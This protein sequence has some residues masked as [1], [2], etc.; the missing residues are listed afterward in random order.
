MKEVCCCNKGAKTSQ[1]GAG[2]ACLRKKGSDGKNGAQANAKEELAKAQA[3]KK[4]WKHI[5]LKVKHRKRLESG[6]MGN[7]CS[8]MNIVSGEVC[9]LLV[10]P[11]LIDDQD[12]AGLELLLHKKVRL[13]PS[14]VSIYI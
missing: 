5:L 14:D 12:M 4:L 11:K 1:G 8:A 3:E 13:A 9:A 6:E 7:V 2:G 10:D